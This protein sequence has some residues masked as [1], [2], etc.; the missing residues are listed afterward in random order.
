MVKTE[1]VVWLLSLGL[2]IY[3]LVNNAVIYNS[4]IFL[5]LLKY[6]MTNPNPYWLILVL[7]AIGTLLSTVFADELIV[8][9]SERKRK[10]HQKHARI[11]LMVLSAGIVL[12]A[13]VL[14][15]VLLQQLH[16]RIPLF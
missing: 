4:T 6:I 5:K 7:S 3:V 9:A 15:Q 14:Y 10:L 12:L 2:N 1:I 16:V 11:W 8:V 13:V